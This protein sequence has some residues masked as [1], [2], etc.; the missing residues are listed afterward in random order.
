[1]AARSQALALA[2]R[3]LRE[4]SVS[5]VVVA[6]PQTATRH[7]QLVFER[8]LL[9]TTETSAERLTRARLYAMAGLVNAGAEDSLVLIRI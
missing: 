4:T 7:L 9:Q 2:R 8:D 5:V 6:L 3:T 1:L